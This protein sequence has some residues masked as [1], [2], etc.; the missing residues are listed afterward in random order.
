MNTVLLNMYKLLQEYNTYGI[1]RFKGNNKILYTNIRSITNNKIEKLD[2]IINIIIKLDKVII[3]ETQH[4]E[5]EEKFYNIN[6]CNEN[7]CSTQ[8]KIEN[9]VAIYISIELN[10]SLID[11][12]NINYLSILKI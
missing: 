12:N 10:S 9:C 7:F 4:R 1:N 6:R 11:K 3:S 5:E 8:S 2:H